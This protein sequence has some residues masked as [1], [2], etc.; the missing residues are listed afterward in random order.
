MVMIALGRLTIIGMNELDLIA[1][2]GEIADKLAQGTGDAIHLREVRLGDQTDSH[3]G[4]RAFRSMLLWR[5]DSCCLKHRVSRQQAR[6]SS[7]GCDE[8][9]F[10]YRAEGCFEYLGS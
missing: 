5:D 10:A 8:S 9:Q 1:L 3:D 4:S 7:P 6:A 2:L